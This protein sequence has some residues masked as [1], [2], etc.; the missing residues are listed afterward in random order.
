MS[1]AMIMSS[2]VSLLLGSLE[3]IHMQ[4]KKK[5]EASW[6]PSSKTKPHEAARHLSKSLTET[7]NCVMWSSKARCRIDYE[8]EKHDTGTTVVCQHKGLVWNMHMGM[9]I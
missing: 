9:T 4:D 1:A 6:H 5:E 3:D 7:W 8:A 2:L